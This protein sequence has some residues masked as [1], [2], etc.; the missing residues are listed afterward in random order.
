MSG[1]GEVLLKFTRARLTTRENAS[2][3]C[4]YGFLCSVLR[5]NKVKNNSFQP[6]KGRKVM[7]DNNITVN[8]VNACLLGGHDPRL[9][10]QLEEETV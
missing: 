6:N 8:P 2:I 7:P 5:T 10:K 1:D 4:Q 3:I 9:Q